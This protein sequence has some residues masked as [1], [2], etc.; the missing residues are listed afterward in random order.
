MVNNC[1]GG[2]YSLLISGTS[3]PLFAHSGA[4]SLLGLTAAVGSTSLVKPLLLWSVGV[5]SVSIQ[6]HHINFCQGLGPLFYAV[7]NIYL[8]L[9]S[10][11][12]WGILRGNIGAPLTTVLARGHPLLTV[13]WDSLP[14]TH[15]G[16]QYSFRVFNFTLIKAWDTVSEDL[17]SIH[18]ERLSPTQYHQIKEGH[19]HLTSMPGLLS[20]A[21]GHSLWSA[22][23][24]GVGVVSGTTSVHSGTSPCMSSPCRIEAS[25]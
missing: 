4:S 2:L 6:D 18:S 23:F 11:S 1:G 19:I 3:N 20:A 14:W 17:M 7:L 8:K 10:S 16:P 15:W 24:G 13:P 22:I 12:S 25:E 21:R 5:P 9:R